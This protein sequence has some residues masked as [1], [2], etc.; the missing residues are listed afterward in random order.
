MKNEVI[1]NFVNDH[2]KRELGILIDKDPANILRVFVPEILAICDKVSKYGYFPLRVSEEMKKAVDSLCVLNPISPLYG[3]DD[4]W[5]DKGSYYQNNRYFGVHKEKNTNK[6]C[7]S[8]AISW[9]A[10]SF[11]ISGGEAY[12][13]SGKK[14]SSTQYIKSFPFM[15]KTFVIDIKDSFMKFVIKDEKQLEEVFKIYDRYDK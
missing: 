3:T 15:P 6:A 5:I 12:T 7:F 14:I 2:A 11:S 1:N 4:E 8:D 10:E 13:K 9:R